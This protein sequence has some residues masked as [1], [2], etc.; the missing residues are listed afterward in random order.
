MKLVQ[1]DI[2]SNM[3]LTLLGRFWS[4]LKVLLSANIFVIRRK[5]QQSY[6]TSDFQMVSFRKGRALVF[7][8]VTHVFV[9]VI[10]PVHVLSVCFCLCCQSHFIFKAMNKWF[11]NRVI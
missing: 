9:F 7:A 2:K 5:T 11:Q 3:M 1:T 4:V 6:I 8:S 10:V